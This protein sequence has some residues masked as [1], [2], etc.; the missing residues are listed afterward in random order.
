MSK[1]VIHAQ[2]HEGFFLPSIRAGGNFK[3]TLPPVDKSL[4]N[5]RMT[6]QDN[7]NLLCEFDEMGFVRSFEVSAANVR[8]S[9]FAPEKIKV[10]VK[11]N[12]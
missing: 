4:E 6:L 9:M 5:F 11:K 12:S 2:L 8:I 1:K 10:D 3:A 7:G